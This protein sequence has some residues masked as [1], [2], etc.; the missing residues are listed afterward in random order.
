MPSIPGLGTSAGLDLRLQ[1]LNDFDYQKLANTAQMMSMQM[2]QDPSMQIAYSTF[3]AD[4]P[5]LYLDVNRTKAEAMKVPVSSIFGILEN[6]LGS[7]YVGDVN[8]GTQINKVIMQSDS[9]Y[10]MTPEDINKMY[11][12]SATGEL[13]PL[14]ALMDMKNILSPRQ[15]SR[16]NQYP[17]ATIMVPAVATSTGEAMEATERIM[18]NLPPGYS[19]EW[20]GMSYQ[21]KQ[22]KGQ[23]NT[24]I[25]LAVLFA[26]LFL[27]A[28]YESWTIPIPVLMSV[29]AAVFG[30]LFGLW[31]TGLPMSIYAQLGLV[32]LVGL[33]AKNAILIVE[34]AKDE[35][36]HGTSI[37]LSAMDGLTQRFRPV[38]M[39]AFTFILGMLPMVIA[40]GAGAASRRALGVPVFYGMLIGT[41][42]GLCL[43]PLFYLLVQ[44]YVEKFARHKERVAERKA[45]AQ[46]EA[47]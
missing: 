47:K 4:T 14:M 26:Y 28:Q 20:T 37:F 2:M 29:V 15:I 22:N 5:N 7:A 3:R 6:Y 19:Y 40:T 8:F 41:L 9:K 25:L 39:T 13:V 33:A 34:F 43:I 45:A 18:K 44:T 46:A 31:I 36:E 24:L 16:Y 38:L 12:T 42:A 23:I 11:V 10:R 35:H 1:S 21:E 17:A 30:G 27:V 32:L